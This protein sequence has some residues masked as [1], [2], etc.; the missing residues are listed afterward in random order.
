MDSDKQTLSGHSFRMGATLD[1]LEQGEPL[2]K[3]MHKG[4]GRQIR[5][6]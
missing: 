1:L 4:D 5:L 2:E 6:P 3:I